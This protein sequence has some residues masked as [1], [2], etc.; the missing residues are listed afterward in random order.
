MVVVVAQLTNTLNELYVSQLSSLNQSM[1]RLSFKNIEKT[2][3]Q[4][5]I[6]HK[7]L[8]HFSNEIYLNNCQC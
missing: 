2:I 5:C 8:E 6:N 7:W 3:R 4:K 1:D